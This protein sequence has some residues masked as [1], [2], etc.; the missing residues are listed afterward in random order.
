[1]LRW[2]AI[3]IAFPF[4]ILFQCL[5]SAHGHLLAH[6]TCQAQALP[7]E[8]QVHDLHCA[9]PLLS[10]LFYCLVVYWKNYFPKKNHKVQRTLV[11]SLYVVKWFSFRSISPSASHQTGKRHFLRLDSGAP[12]AGPCAR[13]RSDRTCYLRVTKCV[14]IAAHKSNMSFSTNLRPPPATAAPPP[15]LVMWLKR[16]EM[17]GVLFSNTL[18]WISAALDDTCFPFFFRGKYVG[19]GGHVVIHKNHES[20]SAKLL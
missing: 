2:I 7:Y 5:A 20:F 11:F 4:P 12:V 6:D 15:L 9:I 3:S 13:N 19:S 16:L 10:L 14:A 8:I 1:M 18:D 17:I